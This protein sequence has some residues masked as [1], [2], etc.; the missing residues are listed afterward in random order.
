MGGCV[1]NLC[2]SDVYLAGSI[3]HVQADKGAS[4]L[5]WP[6]LAAGSCYP[7]ISLIYTLLSG[8]FL[9]CVFRC[10]DAAASGPR[11]RPTA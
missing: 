9:C 2:V 5:W 3:L 10:S 4:P 1:N 7:W 6:V 8:S 11:L